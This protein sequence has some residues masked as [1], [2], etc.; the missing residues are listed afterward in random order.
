MVVGECVNVFRCVPWHYMIV[1]CTLKKNRVAISPMVGHMVQTPIIVVADM[2]VLQELVRD[3]TKPGA[4]WSI[5]STGS[6]NHGLDGSLLHVV[7]LG[8]MEVIFVCGNLGAFRV[9]GVFVCYL[10]ERGGGG[11]S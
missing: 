4:V 3:S 8:N 2:D 6:R 11:G 10:S 7:A 5:T 9:Q 1:A